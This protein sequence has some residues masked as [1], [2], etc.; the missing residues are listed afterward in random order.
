MISSLQAGTLLLLLF[1][2]L[3]LGACKVRLRR[4]SA[5]PSRTLG[6]LVLEP[7]LVEPQRQSTKCSTAVPI[8]LLDTEARGHIG[9]RLL[10]QQAGGVLTEDPVWRWASS[11][12][13]YMDTVLRSEVAASPGIKLVDSSG[14]T[15]LSA[16]LLE[17]ALDSENG[18]R[19]V[20]AVEFQIT[21][22]DRVVRTQTVKASEPVSAGLPGDLAAAAGR[23][24][25]R[26]ASDGLALVANE[27][28]ISARCTPPVITS[29]PG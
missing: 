2:S 1:V 16:T 9:R 27:Q 10:H 22:A 6:P 12:G 8:R 18:T 25:R 13:L 3:G 4:P 7:Q 23:L 28:L 20:G 15:V 17:W 26:L 5:T 11:P 29:P 21:G 24:L 19:L 14:V